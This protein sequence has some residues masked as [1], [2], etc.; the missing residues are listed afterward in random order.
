MSGIN[1]INGINTPGSLSGSYKEPEPLYTSGT[2]Q[3]IE[4]QYLNNEDTSLTGMDPQIL[5][6][7]NEIQT[8]LTDDEEA[9]EEL[10][11][12]LEE[13]S[14]FATDANRLSKTLDGVMDASDLTAYAS[15]LGGL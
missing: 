3:N 12:I 9:I 11:A 8:A 7:G 14:Q 2:N 13:L 1:N 5:A 4:A 15:I 10:K 6:L